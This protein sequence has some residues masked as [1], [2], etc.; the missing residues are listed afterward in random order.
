MTPRE[1]ATAYRITVVLDDLGTW[2]S[3]ELVAE[4]EAKPPTIRVNRNALPVGSSCAVAEAIERAVAHELYHH[5]EAIGEVA[6]L[7]SRTERE[8]A[9]EAFARSLMPDACVGDGA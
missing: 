1:R 7:A 2:G 9:A 5:R 3:A 8:A 6:R 4:Y